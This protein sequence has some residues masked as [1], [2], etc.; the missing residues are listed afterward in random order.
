MFLLLMQ[1]RDDQAFPAWSSTLC[2]PVLIFSTGR[3]RSESRRSRFSAPP[4][5]FLISRSL[6]P[7]LA[8]TPGCPSGLLLA[9]GSQRGQQGEKSAYRNHGALKF[10][11]KK[12]KKVPAAPLSSVDF[13]PVETVKQFSSGV[14]EIDA[15]SF[16]GEEEKFFSSFF[17]GTHIFLI[18]FSRRVWYS[19]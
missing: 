18:H 12:K 2:A 19:T 5:V 16:R 17:L 13:T 10:G 4:L 7:E 14:T 3:F 6:S 9:S 11:K 1:S 15:R 8:V